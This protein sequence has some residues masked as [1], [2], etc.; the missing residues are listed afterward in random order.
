L[1]CSS[2]PKT[3]QHAISVN[4]KRKQKNN[5]SDLW[6]RQKWPTISQNYGFGLQNENILKIVAL[7][8][9]YSKFL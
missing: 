8:F 1:K 9:A 3:W 4:Q 6:V 7:K 2:K 5:F